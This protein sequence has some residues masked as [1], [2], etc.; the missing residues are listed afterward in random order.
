[1]SHFFIHRVRC[2]TTHHMVRRS[3]S[4]RRS[5]RSRRRSRGGAYRSAGQITIHALDAR[6]ARLFGAQ[7]HTALYGDGTCHPDNMRRS[8]FATEMCAWRNAPPSRNV[9][10][11][12]LDRSA[13][14]ALDGPDQFV[15]CIV[16]DDIRNWHHHFPQL[17]CAR[18]AVVLCSL[19]VAHAYRRHR[20]GA[21]L[22]RTAVAACDGREVLLA[23][24]HRGCYDP[25]ADIRNAVVAQHGKLTRY[26]PQQGFHKV[27]TPCENY[28]VY[29][30]RYGENKR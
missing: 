12:Y 1:M 14:V 18:D 7:A 19:C 8:C 16:L 17:A 11:G 27:P 13:F 23:V 3:A 10:A 5:P 15:G 21:R 28:D 22:L 9:L 6:L 25:S 30:Y 26:Y 4:K 2:K 20:V 29:R 24:N